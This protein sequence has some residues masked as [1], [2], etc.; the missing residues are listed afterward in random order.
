MENLAIA[1]VF[2]EI[3]DLLEIKSEN[4]FKIRAYRNAAE[5]IAHATDK[6][7]N[8]TD[9]Q[10]RAIPGIGKE[11]A[12]KIRELAES[13]DMR[14]HRELREQFPPTILD[15]LRLQGVG[16]KTVAQLYTEAGIR[17]IEE[18]ESACR[19]GR[20]RDLKGMGKKKEEL[21]L[22][23]LSD[24]KERSGRHL[25]PN[26]AEAA[27]LLLEYL[28]AACP[29]IDFSAVGSLRRGVD[30]IGDIDILA[31]GTDPRVMNTFT[32]Y[33]LVDRVLAQGDTKS[34]VLLRGGIQADLRLVPAESHGA[35]LQYFTG[36]KAHNIALRDRAISRGYKLN[37][38]GLFRVSDGASVAGKTETEIYEA[39][40]LDTIPPELREG[41][42]E[43]DAAEQR[44]LP[45][46]IALEDIRGDIHTHTTATDGR[47]GIEEMA[48]A[49]RDAGF[50]YLAITDHSKALAMANGLDEHRA[51][52][53]ARRIRE[54]G[55]RLDGITLLAGIE[56][57]IR[58]DG[59]MDLADD[60]LAQ[61]DVVVA[62]VHSAFNQDEAQM[63]DR[64]LRAVANP[65]VDIIG[66]PTGRR[67]LKREPYAIN[68]AALVDAA[69]S[70]GV[71][72]EINSHAER[73]DLCDTHA[74]LARDKGVKI[75]ISTDS[76]S[77]SGFRLMKWGVT[78][79]RRAW[80]TAGDVLNTRSASDFQKGLRRNLELKT[81][82]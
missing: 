47:E 12:A 52:D 19:D 33:T 10:L 57:D 31:A 64:M 43:M 48:R 75:V 7:S 79:A 61:L 56:C 27:A 32:L 65:Y 60:C 63:T 25:M 5:T 1:R 35:A 15:L 2:T 23:A 21:I 73:L 54:I 78:V 45:R 77:R 17:T 67:L 72:L 49:A 26:A 28:R 13:G 44:M 42:G 41:R 36:S 8:C 11:L 39:L 24:R 20:V 9:Q 37:E 38:Y 50:S 6:L 76:H 18:L 68:V 66:H 62:S 69:A 4:P 71:A 40:G 59:S 70:A 22:Q 46:L 55:A 82:N 51:L 3:A 74:K 58:P 16:P 53:H 30:T 14:Y 81:E 80:L 34:S 29:T